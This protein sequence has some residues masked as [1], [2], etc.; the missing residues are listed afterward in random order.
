MKYFIFTLLLSLSLQAQSYINWQPPVA[1]AKKATGQSHGGHGGRKAKQFQLNNS[2]TAAAYEAFY[3]LPT[4]EKRPLTLEQSRVFLPKS[5][6]DNYHALVINQI[7]DNNVNSTVRYIYGHGRPSKTSPTKITQL[8]KS[9]LEIA[10][11]PLPREHDRY[12]G[13]NTYHFELRFKGEALS[14]TQITLTTSNGSEA[15]FKSDEDGE[16]KITL[17]NDFNNVKA[18]RR[19]NRPA[20]FILKAS[21]ADEDVNYTTTLSMPYHVNPIDYWQSRP[22][23]VAVVFLGLF[24]GLFLFRN[25]HKKKKGKI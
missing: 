10:P 11:T 12:K 18:A 16:F 3:I 5:G 8:K 7:H 13:S 24:I 17:P 6:M 15:T 23:A 19:A 25:I 1:K 22:M 4:L 9:I 2:D 20:E 21:Y 14:N